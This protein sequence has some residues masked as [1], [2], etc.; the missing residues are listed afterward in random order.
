MV[1]EVVVDVWLGAGG[2][3]VLAGVVTEGAAG[4]AESPEEHAA[5]RTAT[6]SA[7]EMTGLTANAPTST[8]Q[9]G[10]APA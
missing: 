7:A 10:Q 5:A 1:D 8:G 9:V 6:T 4:V 2:A 3:T